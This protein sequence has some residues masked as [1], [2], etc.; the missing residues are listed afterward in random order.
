MKKLFL[1]LFF[2]FICSSFGQT[3]GTGVSLPALCKV[4]D[5]YT[6][7]DLP[8]TGNLFICTAT[9]IWTLHQGSLNHILGSEFGVKCDSSAND[10]GA[11]TGALTFARAN[12][13]SLVILPAGICRA[14]ITL[15]TN[16]SI[17]GSGTAI[18]NPGFSSAASSTSLKDA[19]TGTLPI[20]GIA[21]SASYITIQNLTLTGNGTGVADR[22]VYAPTASNVLVYNVACN[23]FGWECI[24]HES[25]TS[26][27][28]MFVSAANTLL[29]RNSQTFSQHY[30]AIYEAGSDAVISRIEATASTTTHSQSTN[31]YVD[32]IMA[33][34]DNGFYTDII[35]ETSELGLYVTGT[36][37]NRFENVRTDLN[38]CSGGQVTNGSNQISNWTAVN[39]G[40]DGNGSW[41]GLTVSGA[42]N[43]LSNTFVTQNNGVT[44]INGITDSQSTS[45]Q[46]SNTWTGIKVSLGSY[47]G[48]AF[49]ASAT[50]PAA[51]FS[52]L[53]KNP[54]AIADGTTTPVI[55]IYSYWKFSQTTP[56][57]I[58]SLT[59]NPGQSAC[60]LGNTNV[61][62]GTS[63]NIKPPN[64]VAQ[65]LQVNQM[66]CYYYDG[67]S[68]FNTNTDNKPNYNFVTATTEVLT[69]KLTAKHIFGQDTPDTGVPVVVL[70]NSAGTSPTG[71]TFVANDQGGVLTFTTGSTPATF[72]IIATLTWDTTYQGNGADC[73]VSASNGNAAGKATWGGSLG[74]SSYVFKMTS[75]A[76]SAT[77][78]YVW[79]FICKQSNHF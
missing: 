43:M 13:N 48:R 5:S 51:A 76:L 73:V 71:M 15:Q 59:G 68:W 32:A 65:P 46:N 28:I 44:L 69:P 18:A 24:R 21:S 8:S 57:T 33:A 41:D 1:V 58:N 42:G 29:N 38:Y 64:G 50:A 23:N 74:S 70:G 26:F 35:G 34:G 16:D 19:S 63:G 17:S 56:L 36:G 25:G 77:T 78:Q 54:I 39:N 37:I 62:F 45:D 55:E 52:P 4:G 20:V 7:T 66:Y 10:S 12:K 60:F 22:G 79:T 72:D 30:G 40:R 47:T 27:Q 14:N 75:P 31:C 67:T 53:N 9:N 6:R 49:N 61:T 11:I 2:V 3:I